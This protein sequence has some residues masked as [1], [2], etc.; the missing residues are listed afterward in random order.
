MIIAKSGTI[1]APIS[2]K[3]N[4]IIERCVS[5]NGDISITHYE[6]LKELN[7]IDNCI[8]DNNYIDNN[9][10]KYISTISVVKCILETGR[11]HQIRVHMAYTGHP[12][13]GDDLYGGNKNLI[14]RQALHSYKVSFIHPINHSKVAFIANLPE[15]FRFMGYA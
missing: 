14:N 9:K 13:L 15:D 10:S 2:R 8:M 5:D 12:L 11:T 4:S 1:N 6:V 3:E 7:I